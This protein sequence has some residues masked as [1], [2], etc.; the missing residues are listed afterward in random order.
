M[1]TYPTGTWTGPAQPKLS[2]SWAWWVDNFKT[3][4]YP[5][6]AKISGIALR[7]GQTSKNNRKYVEEELMKGARTLRGKPLT[8]NHDNKNIAGTVE[9]S[10]Y[11]NG[12]LHY[13]ATVKKEPYK[14]MVKE[15]DARIKGVSIEGQYINL[16]CPTCREHFETEAYFKAHMKDEHNILQPISEVHGLHLDSL[17]LVVS[18][19]IPGVESTTLDVLE[20]QEAQNRIFETIQKDRTFQV[21]KDIPQIVVGKAGQTTELCDWSKTE[22]TSFDDCVAKNADKGD[23]AAYCAGIMRKVTGE[24][25]KPEKEP[26]TFDERLEVL[27]RA[28]E[29]FRATYAEILDAALKRKVEREKTIQHLKEAN[30]ELQ[31]SS[32]AVKEAAVENVQKAELTIQVAAMKNRESLE[33]TK[34]QF[35]EMERRAVL[36]ENALSKIHG[37]FKALNQSTTATKPEPSLTWKPS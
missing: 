31:V 20:M 13:A 32:Y 30:E 10:E 14:T 16:I 19:E 11:E 3:S 17:S 4:E 1:S 33:K 7:G 37:K 26:G 12:E 34:S 15:R 18:P 24:T 29:P 23:A 25:K 22:Y 21:V 27:S 5:G 8:V 9:L 36:A 2:E 35:A 6:S 28:P